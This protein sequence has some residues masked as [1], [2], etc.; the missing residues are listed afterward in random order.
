M[1]NK[2]TTVT[3]F[4]L[5]LLG[6][7]IML[8][9]LV[10]SYNIFTGVTEVPRVF[11][12]APEQTSSGSQQN[13]TQDPQSQLEQAAGQM[14]AEQLKGLLPQDVLPTLFNLVSWSVFAAIAI[15]TG[16]QIAG[17]GIKLLK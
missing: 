12:F 8:W 13:K 7:S 2:M 6:L 14:I 17:L 16:T 10:Y 1:T 9:S 15:F 4:V 3:G 11:K 5:L